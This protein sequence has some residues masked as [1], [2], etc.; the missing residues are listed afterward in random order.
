MILW[1]LIGIVVIGMVNFLV[2]FGLSM[3]LAFRSRNIPLSEMRIVAASIWRHFKRRPMSFFF[4]NFLR[5]KEKATAT[6]A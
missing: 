4:P 1:A 6:E 2:S 5:G 3:G